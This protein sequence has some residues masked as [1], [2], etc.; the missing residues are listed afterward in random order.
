MVGSD[1]DG[2]GYIGRNAVD[3]SIATT[4][5]GTNGAIGEYSFAMGTNTIAS[6]NGSIAMGS[7]SS[8]Y[9]A[10]STAIGSGVY[11]RSLLE[12]VIG[13]YNSYYMPNDPLG[14]DGEDRLF[15]IGKGSTNVNTSDALIVLKNGTIT[16]PSLSTALINTAG[17]KALITKEY[18][19][20]NYLNN[21]TNMIPIAYGS[22]SSTGTT[23]FGGTGNFTVSKNAAHMYTI[24]V[25]GESID[26]TNSTTTVSTISGAFKTSSISHSSG[27][28]RVHIFDS[29]FSQV[30]NS[31][32]FVIY[33][34]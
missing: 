14:W 1:H 29:S 23:I 24:N 17:N 30:A 19:D 5:S 20:T 34:Q 6:G 15:S 12:T 31:F 33:K 22:I 9:G 32:Q 28:V 2:Y 11:A 8:A 10:G 16:A 21:T 27:N 25:N 26:H 13:R 18:A 4:G 3:L 7:S